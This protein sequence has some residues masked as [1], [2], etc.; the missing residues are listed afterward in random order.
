M[1]IYG[2]WYSNVLDVQSFRE[3]DGVTD[4]YLVVEKVRERLAVSKQT[5]HRFHT[6][7]FSFKKL[8]EEVGKEQYWVEI[9]N[10]IAVLENSDAEVD[11][12]R[13]WK[14]III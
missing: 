3:A 2:R 1:L 10:R 5:A 14:T 6:E 11:I 12:N 9:S 7:R 8:N 4:H 13:S